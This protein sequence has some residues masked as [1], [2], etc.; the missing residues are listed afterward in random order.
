L[1]ASLGLTGAIPCPNG[2]DGSSYDVFLRALST[3]GTWSDESAP[4]TMLCANVPDSPD[5]LNLLLSAI[6]LILISW[7]PPLSDGGTPILGY[8][9]WMK[10]DGESD[11]LLSYNGT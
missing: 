2:A 6:D 3:T 10:A 9:V 11:Y 5:S 4:V 8:S 1:D 7:K